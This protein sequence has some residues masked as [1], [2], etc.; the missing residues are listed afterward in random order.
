MACSMDALCQAYSFGFGPL[1]RCFTYTASDQVC[2]ASG[3]TMRYIRNSGRIVQ[4]INILNHPSGSGYC[5]RRSD[6]DQAAAPPP[7]PE[8]EPEPQVVHCPAGSTPLAGSTYCSD[9][10][11]ECRGPGESRECRGPGVGHDPV[12]CRFKS[13]VGTRADCQA[14]C[15]AAPACVGYNYRA[16]NEDCHLFGPGLDRDLGGGWS[17]DTHT[18][19]TIGAVNSDSRFVCVVVAGRNVVNC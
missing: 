6:V 7:P 4:S 10:V 11:G 8:P 19:T 1:F 14:E 15:N 16:S 5:K 12:N 17:A 9:L 13:Y 18:T 2:A 3:G